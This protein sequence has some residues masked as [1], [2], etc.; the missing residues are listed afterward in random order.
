MINFLDDIWVRYQLE[1]NI[2]TNKNEDN[3][4]ILKLF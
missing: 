2:I 3:R 4:R 1:N